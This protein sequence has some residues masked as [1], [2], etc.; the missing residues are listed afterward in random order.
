MS[1]L[2]LSASA[3]KA[4]STRLRLTSENIANIDTPGYR[5]KIV[6]FREVSNQSTGTTS[7]TAGQVHLDQ[8]ELTK[9][10][11]PGHPLADSSGYFT[12]SNVNLMLEIADAR[13][14]QRT[15]E[16]NLRMIDQ[17]RRMASSAL[18]LLRR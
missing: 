7:I 5:R 17:A 9:T 4:Q 12:G 1:T 3:M 6:S 15:Y 11:D 8:S 16:A 13:E 10:Y 18:D 2:S 14:S